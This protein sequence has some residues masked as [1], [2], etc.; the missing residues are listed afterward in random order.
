M[1]MLRIV[2]SKIRINGSCQ[3]QYGK[4]ASRTKINKTGRKKRSK[5]QDICSR[6]I[7]L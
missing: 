7:L 4:G 2:R 3:L 5:D 6:G 1:S